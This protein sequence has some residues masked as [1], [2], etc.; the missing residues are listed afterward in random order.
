MKPAILVTK[1]GSAFY[2]RRAASRA[3][4]VG[5]QGETE[6]TLRHLLERDD[7]RVVYFGAYR[8]EALDGLTV[9][10]PDIEGHDEWTTFARQKEGFE[11]DVA[12]LEPH[13]PFVGY[14][15]V[16]GYSPTMSMIDN[17]KAS[18]VQAQS[19]R[20]QAPMLNVLERFGLPRLVVNNDPRTYPKDQE[21]SLGWD[22]ARPEALLDQCDDVKQVVVGG[23]SYTRRS[24]WA[25]P[26]SWAYH[27]RRENTDE[28]PCVVIAHAHIGDGCKMRD[29]GYSWSNVL[30]FP[31]PDG[32]RVYGR[33]WEHYPGYD[34]EVMPGPVKPN[35]VMDILRTATCCPCVSAGP[36]FYTGKVYVC[37]AQGCVPLLY[38]DGADPFTWDPEGVIEPLDSPWRV[39]KPGDLLARVNLLR[40]SRADREERREFW[41]EA[42]RPRWDVLDR[43]VDDLLAGRDR[44]SPSWFRD[45]GGYRPA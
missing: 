5:E 28:L 16:A 40:R 6:G 24:V 9:V 15:C 31:R 43:L 36:K 35:E 21:M 19:V 13:G 23:R 3:S 30:G 25:R 42:C 29:R 32:L 45:Y 17:P 37:E 18:T 39:V 41:R 20:Y 44:T 4:N 10:E 12:A 26:E 11:N 7:V 33:G 8:G 1:S 38:G 27:I 34:P 22:R 14:L 2:T